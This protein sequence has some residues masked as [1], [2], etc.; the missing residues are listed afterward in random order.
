MQDDPE[1]E[2]AKLK[3]SLSFYIERCMP[4]VEDLP[5]DKRHI[6]IREALAL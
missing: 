4:A 2:Y 3:D 6:A 1:L 5:P